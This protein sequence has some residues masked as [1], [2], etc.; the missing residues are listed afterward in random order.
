MRRAAPRQYNEGP[1]AGSECA[2]RNSLPLCVRWFASASALVAAGAA[3][4]ITVTYGFERDPVQIPFRLIDLAPDD[5]IAPRLQ[6]SI[7]NGDDEGLGAIA[8]V[9]VEFLPPNTTRVRTTGPGGSFSVGGFLSVVDAPLTPHTAVEFSMPSFAQIS[10]RPGESA[11][12]SIRLEGFFMS[13]PPQ[14]GFRD[15][16]SVGFGGAVPMP[17]EQNRV[18]TGRLE[19]NTDQMQ[20]VGYGWGFDVGVGSG[21]VT[22]VPEPETWAMLALGL[23]LVMLM[24][25][26]RATARPQDTPR[27]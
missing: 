14:G 9:I 8:P 5:G 1:L 13:G 17:T 26:R 3:Q 27:A 12:V 7:V 22:P 15:G 24:G 4:A 2:M 10:A 19:N 25:R 6:P 11:N 23:P 16:F 18:L 20:L 21:N